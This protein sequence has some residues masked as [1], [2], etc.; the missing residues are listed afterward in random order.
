MRKNPNDFVFVVLLSHTI[1]QYAC[2]GNFL[3]VIQNICPSLSFFDTCWEYWTP[4]YGKPA[5]VLQ[6]QPAWYTTHVPT[7]Q[8][9]N[10]CLISMQKKHDIYPQ[11][12]QYCKKGVIVVNM[13]EPRW[14]VHKIKKM[15]CDC[16]QHILPQNG[17]SLLD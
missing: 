2:N 10:L 4:S 12:C 15:V 7:P 17:S 6:I 9:L 1:T 16:I 14:L 13:C 3:H 5:V 8:K 11:K